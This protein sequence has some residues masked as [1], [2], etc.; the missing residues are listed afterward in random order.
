MCSLFVY[1]FINHYQWHY[2]FV[3][4]LNNAKNSFLNIEF[5]NNNFLKSTMPS[6]KEYFEANLDFF[7]QHL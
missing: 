6:F 7:T 1:L 3:L 4:L 2:L 5:V